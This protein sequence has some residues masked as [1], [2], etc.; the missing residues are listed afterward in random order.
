MVR[1]R[2]DILRTALQVL[3][4][5]G[6]DAVTHQHVAR[7]A[8]YSKATVYNHWP[9]RTDLLGD[10]FMRLNDLPHHVPTGDLRTDLIGEMT[11]FR[12]AMEDQRLDRALGL[13][14]E[15]AG[16]TP[17]LDEVR[18][19]LVVDGERLLRELLGTVLQ[20]SELEAAI[21]MLAGAVLQCAMLHGEPLG[22]EVIASAVDLVLGA[23]GGHAR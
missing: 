22:D 17:G 20:G 16:S 18:H 5:E 12:T 9:T 15:L 14:I 8:G 11:A 7:T 2:T 1:T 4:E 19:R 23:A 10:A 6:W 3:M 13:L 21:V